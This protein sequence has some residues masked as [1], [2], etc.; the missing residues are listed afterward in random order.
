MR[1]FG[2]QPLPEPTPLEAWF[3][4]EFVPAMNKILAGY[5][6]DEL[7]VP[8]WDKPWVFFVIRRGDGAEITVNDAAQNCDEFER[9]LWRHCDKHHNPY[10][11]QADNGRYYKSVNEFPSRATKATF[12][13]D[14]ATW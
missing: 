4:Q 12:Y 10:T 2:R 14:H 11:V 5:P 6:I 8:S 13:I 1:L 9:L 7:R 3:Y